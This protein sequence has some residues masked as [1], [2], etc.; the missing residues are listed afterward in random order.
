MGSPLDAAIAATEPPPTPNTVDRVIDRLHD[1]E[2]VDRLLD[3][4]RSPISEWG[5]KRMA[6]I[7]RDVCDELGVDHE[8]CSQKNVEEW[9][10]RERRVGS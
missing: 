5:H 9:R 10:K 6:D 1:F 7:I 3:M 8:D 4:L 2:D